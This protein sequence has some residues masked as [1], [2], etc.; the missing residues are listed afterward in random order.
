MHASAAL[1]WIRIAYRDASIMR[2]MMRCIYMIDNHTCIGARARMI[3]PVRSA[4]IRCCIC[5]VLYTSTYESTSIQHRCLILRTIWG[6][7]VTSDTSCMWTRLSYH[8]MNDDTWFVKSIFCCR[9]VSQNSWIVGRYSL[10]FIAPTKIQL[11]L[12]H[13]LV[14]SCGFLQTDSSTSDLWGT[15]IN[16]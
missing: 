6:S 1:E 12:Y 4:S 10:A 7:E 11:S 14:E 3:G 16:W 15:R 2:C 9:L 13:L 8:V 5:R